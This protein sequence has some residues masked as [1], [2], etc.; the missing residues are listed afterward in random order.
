MKKYYYLFIMMV[1]CSSMWADNTYNLVTKSSISF[2]P[3]GAINSKAVFSVSP[4]K[5]VIFSKGNLQYCANPSSEPTT[6]AVQGGGTAPGIWRFAEHQYEFVGDNSVKTGNVTGSTN[7]DASSTYS[8]WID[9]FGWGT[10][11]YLD[12]EETRSPVYYMPY[13]HTNP[14]DNTTP[15]Y[16]ANSNS[17]LTNTNYDWGYYNAIENGGG[18]PGYWRVLT[19]E[20]WA[21]LLGIFNSSHPNARSGAESKRTMVSVHG[22]RG[23][24]ILP[25]ALTA[26]ILASD[27]GISLTISYSSFQTITD[28]EWDTLESLGVAFLPFSC[29]R[30]QEN[31][32]YD[33]PKYWAANSGNSG[34]WDPSASDPSVTKAWI[35]SVPSSNPP[36][37][38]NENRWKGLCVRLVYDL[39]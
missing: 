2:V 28:E 33:T 10:S 38:G 15:R 35:M 32:F 20:E 26:S 27:Y 23:M 3:E 29:F 22:K 18:D 8:G 16:G 7:N 34:S 6:H 5:K 37:I 1:A 24:L 14:N 12:P 11:G 39:Q 19:R 17:S 4:T 36:S 9:L 13:H 25:D 31:G 30:N 21:Y